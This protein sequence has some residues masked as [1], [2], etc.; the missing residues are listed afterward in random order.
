MNGVGEFIVEQ[1]GFD[2]GVADADCGLVNTFKNFPGVAEA[3]MMW[4]CR[5]ES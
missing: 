1:E 3:A 5:E 2:D 4:V